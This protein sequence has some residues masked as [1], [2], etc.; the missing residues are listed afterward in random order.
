MRREV[1]EDAPVVGVA[2]RDRGPARNRLVGEPLL[3]AHRH[4]APDRPGADAARHL[5]ELR[6]EQT[7]VADAH[8]HARTRRDVEDRA[9]VR[10]VGGQRLL[11]VEVGAVGRNRLDQRAVR[12][13]RRQQVDDVGPHLLHHAVQVG[14]RA[15]DPVLRGES[16]GGRL[17]EVAHRDHLGL[18]L[19]ADRLDVDRGDAARADQGGAARVTRGHRTRHGS[20]RMMWEE[21]LGGGRHASTTPV[22]APNGAR[23][24]HMCGLAGLDGAEHE[25]VGSGVHRTSE[26]FRVFVVGAPTVRV[27]QLGPR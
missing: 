5:E 13:R 17:L 3:G 14:V 24:L 25:A 8:P 22:D 27:S 4:D 7:V 26:T 2:P 15:R 16:V 6:V 12:A 18:P 1:L 9:R 11:H 20:P 10:L 23:R 19:L 21:R